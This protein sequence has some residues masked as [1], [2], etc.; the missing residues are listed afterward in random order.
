MFPLIKRALNASVLPVKL[1]GSPWSPPA[2]MK[3]N[4]QMDGSGFPGLIQDL[5]IFASWALYLSKTITEY[6]KI[7]INF[8][9]LTIQNESEFAAP[10]EACCYNASQQLDFLKNYLGPQMKRDHPNVSIMIFDHNKDHVAD[11]VQTF[12]SDPLGVQ[13]ADGT[14][15]HWY[16]GPQFEN[17]A[18]AHRIAPDKFLLM[19]EGSPGPL[20]I[21][22][23]QY[24]ERVGFDV[25]GD[26][27]NWAVGWVAWNIILDAQGGPNHLNGHG[28]API[29]ADLDAQKLIYEPEFFYL[30]HFSRYITPD[31]LILNTTVSN[32]YLLSA[33]A[34]ITP[35]GDIIVVLQNQNDTPLSYILQHGSKCAQ[36]IIPGHSIQTL[37]YHM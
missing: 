15:F 27:N 19:T 10:W 5:K 6:A 34:A 33:V 22:N 30:G 26:L 17:L 7:G 23:W 8:W 13:Y 18:K 37:V 36:T 20:S 3:T 16:T 12:F 1:F 9:G 14:A 31:S 32:L 24:G 28:D 25:I 21:G 35:T 11:W 2:W 29:I 4:N